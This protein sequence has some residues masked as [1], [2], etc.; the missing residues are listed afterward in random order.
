MSIAEDT[1][2]G[3]VTIRHL[4]KSYR[5]NGAP[6]QVLRDIN[7]HVRSGESLA[8]VGASGSGKTTLL[9][10]L[11]GLEDSDT[12]EVLVDGQAIRGVG[13]ERAVIFQEPRLLPWLT[14]LDN[15]AFGLETSGLS[16]EQARGRARHYVKLVGLQQFEAAYPRQLSGG[17]A[18]RVGIARAL[19]VQ[20]EILLLD[21]PL[22]ALDAMTKIGMQQ[23]LARIWRDED[24]TTILVTHDLEEAI[25]LADRILILPREKG[26][27]PRLIEI[28]LPRPR[29]RSAPEFVRHREE[30]LNLFGLH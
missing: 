20:P 27:E 7:L 12:G 24:V 11:A 19:A 9:R 2:R 8:I 4:S 10:V 18:Q 3:E 14:V 5:L 13:T 6:L 30:L 1:R 25:Y 23:E 26:G 15:V 21:E 28:D 29:D 22:G 17:M 16:R